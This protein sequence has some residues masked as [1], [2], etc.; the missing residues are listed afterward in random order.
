VG[1]QC[2]A[3]FTHAAPHKTLKDI[4]SKLM[5]NVPAPALPELLHHIRFCRM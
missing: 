5:T 1:K 4:D 3:L 2:E